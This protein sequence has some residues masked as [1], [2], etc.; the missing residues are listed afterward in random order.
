MSRIHVQS[1]FLLTDEVGSVS[2]GSTDW[3]EYDLLKLHAKGDVRP[4]SAAQV[5]L[6][7]GDHG[8]VK[9]RVRV[10][11][12]WKA[13]PDGLT[14]ITARVLWMDEADKA[15]WEDFL[16]DHSTWSTPNSEGGWLD[17]VSQSGDVWSRAQIGRTR[18]R[19]SI[20]DALRSSLGKPPADQDLP[21]ID[22]EIELEELQQD[23][24]ILL[25]A[26]D[27]TVRWASYEALKRDWER[28][29]RRGVF[30]FPGILPPSD[31]KIILRFEF[32][33]GQVAALES[34]LAVADDEHEGFRAVFR[35][36]PALRYKIKRLVKQ[37]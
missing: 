22:P 15:A 5:R 1:A 26:D 8:T 2:F 21:E 23:P 16:G 25:G 34:S 35:V 17:S 11:E 14:E 4:G 24:T 12:A 32:P 33:D 28:F 13:A 7:L 3:L 27:A 9:L 36:G 20:R 29:L 37:V 30:P 10:I 19:A 31:G 6:D 18:G